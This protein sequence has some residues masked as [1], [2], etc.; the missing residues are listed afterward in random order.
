MKK[1]T[2]DAKYRIKLQVWFA[3]SKNRSTG[4]KWFA[5]MLE[6]TPYINH[7]ILL[8]SEDTFFEFRGRL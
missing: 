7:T 2:S 4:R 1:I 6:L 3:F 5:F 8:L